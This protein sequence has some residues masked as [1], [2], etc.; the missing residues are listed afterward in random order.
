MQVGDKFFDMRSDGFLPRNN[1]IECYHQPGNCLFG[2][3]FKISPVLFE[4][5]I[6]FSEYKGYISPLSYLIEPFIIQQVKKASSFDERIH[7]LSGYFEHILQKYVGS[8]QSIQIVTGI[9]D[10]CNSNNNF[11]VS[12]EELGALYHISARTLNRY[13]ESVTS[14]SCK[15][16]LQ[17]MRVRKATHHLATSPQTFHYDLYGYYDHSHFYKQL[18]IFLQKDTLAG[19]R[20]HLTLLKSLHK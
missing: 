12:M 9:L 13:F 17:I 2:I 1:A 5:K 15:K 19:I 20:P 16:A 8:L 7:L 18:K 4:K 6:N 3:K 14:L 11:S 10:H